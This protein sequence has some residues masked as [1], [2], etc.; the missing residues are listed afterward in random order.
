MVR[1]RKHLWKWRYQWSMRRL[2]DHL[3]RLFLSSPFHREGHDAL[4]S[5]LET[6]F[7]RH[8]WINSWLRHKVREGQYHPSKHIQY[9]RNQSE[10]MFNKREE[11]VPDESQEELNLD[12]TFLSCILCL[13]LSSIL[14]QI[15]GNMLLFSCKRK[16]GHVFC[17]L[18]CQQ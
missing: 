10:I 9:Q 1:K 16:I 4:P 18:R 5:Q 3:F 7:L 17:L 2:D 15:Q 11:C 13:H 8:Q 14:Q 12:Q 6:A